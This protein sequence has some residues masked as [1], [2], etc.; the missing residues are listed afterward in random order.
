ML[1]R[2]EIQQPGDHG[3]ARNP[4]VLYSSPLLEQIGS[5]DS[6]TPEDGLARPGGGRSGV[7][8][9]FSTRLGGVSTGPF[10]SLNL[11]NPNGQAQQDEKSNLA[12][13]YRRLLE[14]AGLDPYISLCRVHQV[15]GGAVVR[16]SADVEHDPHAMAD[17]IVSDD[18]T[19]AISVRVADCVPVLLASRDGR[20]VGAVHAGWRGVVAGVVG[21]AVKTMTTEFDGCADPAGIVAAIGPCIGVDAFEVGPEVVAEFAQVFS[22]A[23]LATI[24][25]P[26]N[27]D[28]RQID[29]REALMR[30]L[31]KAGVQA[32]SIDSSDRCTYR[33]A[34]EFFSHRR[35]NGLTG[36]MVGIIAARGAAPRA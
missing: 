23:D 13:N 31:L 20:V 29:L 2:R 18:P 1:E 25:R 9:A 14:A 30:Q 7:R 4:V 3:A 26:G 27:Q 16:L 28:R 24:V 21:A 8:H 36:R 32:S 5:T 11:G 22:G 17:A 34:D 33:D 6:S 15:H 35:E 12:M 19:R 10:A